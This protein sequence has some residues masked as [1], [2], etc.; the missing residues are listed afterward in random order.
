MR[1]CLQHQNVLTNILFPLGKLSRCIRQLPYCQDKIPH[2]CN[3]KRKKFTF[4]QNFRSPAPWLVNWL[5]GRKIL[6]SQLLKS[7]ALEKNQRGSGTR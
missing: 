5:E 2:T 3:V 4:G 7:R 1:N 6:S